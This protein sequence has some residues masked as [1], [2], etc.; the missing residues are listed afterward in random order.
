MEIL[1]ASFRNNPEKQAI[2]SYYRMV[3]SYRNEQGRV[4]HRTLLNIGFW[5]EASRDQKTKVSSCFRRFFIGF[6]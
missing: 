5:E 3:E 6:S 2:S 4:C 1:K